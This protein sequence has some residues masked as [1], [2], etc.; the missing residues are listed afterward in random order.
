MSRIV[1][2]VA[3]ALLVLAGDASAAPPVVAT[4]PLTNGTADRVVC[5]LTNVSDKPIDVDLAVVNVI[6]V[7]QQTNQGTLNPGITMAAVDTTPADS[8]CRATGASPKK[9]R[10]SLC[11]ATAALNCISVATAP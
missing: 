3:L 1:L 2:S 7:V 9:V 4:A 5:L 10:L 11:M 6:G 8:Y